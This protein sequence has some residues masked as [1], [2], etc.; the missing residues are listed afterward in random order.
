MLLSFNVFHSVINWFKIT[1]SASKH[2]VNLPTSDI[3]AKY[4]HIIF[5]NHSSTYLTIH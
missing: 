4:C 1:T 2:I 3:Q 5:T